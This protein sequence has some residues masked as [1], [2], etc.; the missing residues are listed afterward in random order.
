M[1]VAEEERSAGAL[2]E[3]ATQEMRGVGVPVDLAGLPAFADHDGGF[4]VWVEVFD[5]EFE[6]LLRPGGGV[7]EQP[8]QCLVP[9]RDVVADVCPSLR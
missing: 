2:A 7:V 1:P 8:P 6:D 9:D 5:V 3:V 4:G